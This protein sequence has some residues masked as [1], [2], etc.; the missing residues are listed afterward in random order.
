MFSWLL[1]GLQISWF[2][3]CQLY[4]AFLR[5]IVN[6]SHL[7]VLKGRALYLYIFVLQNEKLKKNGFRKNVW[8]L[9]GKGQKSFLSRGKGRLYSASV[10]SV[11][12][13]LS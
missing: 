6:A 8:P 5:Q 3:P 4:K 7:N 2:S 13:Y 1:C 10:N 12:L 11:I 9:K